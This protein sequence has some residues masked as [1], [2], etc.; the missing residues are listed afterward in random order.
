M[1]HHPPL[2]LLQIQS[3]RARLKEV[4]RGFFCSHQYLEVETPVIV[5]APGTEIHLNYFATTWQ[6]HQ[7]QAHTMYLRSS[8]ELHLKQLLAPPPELTPELSQIG[9]PPL[10]QQPQR[11]F[12]FATCFRNSGELSPWHHPEFTMLEYYQPG[13][14]LDAFIDLTTDLSQLVSEQVRHPSLPSRLPKHFERWTV[15][16]AFKAF[17]NLDLI[18]G[19]P[20]LARKALAQGILSITGEEDFETAFFKIIID[21]LEPAF[22][23]IGGVVLYDY[24]PSQAALAKVEDGWAKRFECYAGRVEL[25]NGFNELTDYDVNRQRWRDGKAQ[26]KKLGKPEIAEDEDYFRAVAQGI[27]ACCGNAMGFERLLALAMGWDNIDQCIPFRKISPYRHQM[28]V[29]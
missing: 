21:R 9:S 2:S 29:D 3:L 28:S 19:D 15:R 8:P 10:P 1:Q 26:R 12:Q 6:D 14:T 7:A 17:A 5:T 16:D 13:I 4:L 18:D 27:P 24:P 25:C 23:R 11:L 22:E 20:D